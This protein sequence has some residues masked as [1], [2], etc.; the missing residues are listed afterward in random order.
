L[1]T[2]RDPESRL[3]VLLMELMDESLTHFLE[4]AQEP[5][6]YHTEV[7]LCHDISLALSYLHSNGIVHRDL[8]SNNVLLIAGS[9][10]KVTDFGMVKLYDVNHSTAHL[11]PLTLCPGTA[12]YMS[13]EALEEPP[14]YTD[15]LDSF[16]L[17]VLGVQIM[18]RQFPDPGDRF[19]VV[20]II[21]PRFPSG[22]AKVDIPEIE[23]RQS[24]IN[25]INPANPLLPVALDCLKDK[26]RERPS[27]HELCGRISALK[28]SPMYTESMQQSR[29]R[30]EP[31]QS[32]QTNKGRE[33]V[34]SQQ[35][36][37]LQQQL[38]EQQLESHQ[39]KQQILGLRVLLTASNEQLQATQQQLTSKDEQLA[40]QLQAKEA[41]ISI[42]QQEI[43]QLQQQLLS[44]EQVTAEFQRNLLESEKTVRDQQR[45]IQELQQQ[46]RQRGGQRRGEEEASGAAASGGSIKLRWRDGGKGPPKMHGEVCAVNGSVAYFRPGGIKENV[47]L[48]YD[49]PKNNWSELPRCPNRDFSLAVVNNLITTIG[50]KTPKDEF[51]S[52]LLSLT[53]KKWTEQFPPM[54]TKRWCTTVVCSGRSLVVAG[55]I[56][57]GA[58]RLSTVEVMDTETPQW[59]TATSLPHTLFQATATLC[60]DQIYML[61]GWE[62]TNKFS[63]SVFTCSLATL[64]SCQ[65]DSRSPEAQM[66]TLSLTSGPEVWHQ[67]ADTPVTLSTCASLHGRLLAVGGKDSDRKLTT[68]IHAYNMT[69]K[70]WEIISHMATARSRCLVAVF[71]HN[72]LMV[73]GGYAPKP[74][75]SVE[76]ATIV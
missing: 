43:Q 63:M 22:S 32:D 39:Q 71:P 42:Y 72:E 51:T 28:A 9:R 34:P 60:G 33:V 5:I 61:G 24:H 44:S 64:Q 50:G 31:T 2:Y 16:S 57:E 27:C 53:D 38:Q 12:V 47:V 70:S 55:G 23:R 59:F 67:L 10:A 62:Q 6:S 7:N 21:D 76:I 8:S 20:P 15:K 58:K 69:T 41:A 18:T 14:V 17:G 54:P 35:I 75:D 66:K 74:T 1:G 48:V 46:L 11:T 25:L 29:V 45:Q 40:D 49:S 36:R 37:D 13:P 56:G 30:A 26:D 73:V 68:A 3:P 4:R 52:S 19:Q 65:S